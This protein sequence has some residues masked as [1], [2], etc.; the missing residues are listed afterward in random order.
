M[1]K[2]SDIFH[3]GQ[4]VEGT[5]L[6]IVDSVH[7]DSWREI[8]V[9]CDCGTEFRTN[10]MPV[11]QGKYSC[12]CRR[13]LRSDSVDITDLCVSNV[14]GNKKYGRT[15]AVLGMDPETQQWQYVCSCC[16]EIFL[17][18]R[19]D[20]HSAARVLKELA[21]TVCPNFRPYYAAEWLEI[22]TNDIQNKL[23]YRFRGAPG[24]ARQA[25]ELA[26]YYDRKHLQFSRTGELEGFWGMPDKPLPAAMK[27]K[28]RAPKQI[29]AETYAES[30]ARARG[31]VPLQEPELPE[32]PAT[33]VVPLDPDGFGE[34][35]DLAG[36]L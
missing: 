13:R 1:K 9:R 34:F 11:Y 36:D 20:S 30:I 12:G 25:L 6:T 33:E 15:L 8:I 5:M 17:L 2:R 23:G 32:T 31:I 29:P 14:N 18:H 10:Y 27:I 24:R 19:G 21:G 28:R 22:L 16:A 35:S 26:A 3:P 4:R 7:P